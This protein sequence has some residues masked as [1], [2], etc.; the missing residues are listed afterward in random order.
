MGRELG[1][2]DLSKV[3]YPEKQILHDWTATF[4]LY[5]QWF[6]VF[7]WKLPFPSSGF[8]PQTYLVFMLGS[9][10]ENNN[11]KTYVQYLYEIKQNKTKSAYFVLNERKPGGGGRSPSFKVRTADR[12]FCVFFPGVSLKCIFKF[13]TRILFFYLFIYFL[14]YTLGS[15]KSL[16]FLIGHESLKSGAEVTQSPLCF[17]SWCVSVVT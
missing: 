1:I 4:V 6:S 5:C 11:N 14:I 17:S 3:L 2:G 7:L 9:W 8:T 16:A 13:A 12:P 15:F 10:R